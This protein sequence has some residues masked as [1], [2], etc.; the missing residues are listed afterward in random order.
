MPSLREVL[1][2]DDAATGVQTGTIGEPSLAV[3]GSSYLVT[4][5]W[6][7]SRSTD[8]G[9]TWT[10]V[11]P[12]VEFPG[13][14]GRF[15]CDQVVHRAGRWWLWLLQNE[16]VR[17]ANVLRLAASSTGAPGTWHWWDLAPTDLDPSWT[18][19]WF[20]FPDVAVTDRH[21]VVSAN[22][23]AG[24]QWRRAVVV[25]YPR[26]ALGRR[27]ALPREHWSTTEVGSL[28]LASHGTTLWAGASDASRG[29]LVVVRWPDGSPDVTSRTVRV[30]AWNDS[31][32]D[33]T[34]PDGSPWLS[35]CD[36]RVTA[37]FATATEVGFGW[38][39]GR[40]SGRP[41]PFCRFAILDASTLK[42]R[43][44]P[45]LWSATGAWAYPA[46]AVSRAGAVG[47]AAYFT[48]PTQPALA[49]GVLGGTGASRAWS[50]TTAATS[51]HPPARGT[52]GDY[53][54]VRA[55][56]TRRT[57][58]VAAGCVLDGGSD[59]RFVEPKVVVFGR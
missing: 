23:Y 13:D 16:A 27:A 3:S 44:E 55:H 53:L 30:G 25:R 38:S 31:A 5:N 39:S 6:Y 54:T 45:D 52:W 59:R 49:V 20:D 15:C 8:Q 40:R 24:E 21:V 47:L 17:G 51:T 28:R 34:G 9:G 42:V 10:F 2:L 35:R 36:D 1:V 12:F 57:S 41:Q 56:P 26:S 48:G 50:M 19:V 4:G 18:G 7:A 14:R 46:T 37:A 32:F 58:W 11:D 43:A 33:S 29:S 22:L